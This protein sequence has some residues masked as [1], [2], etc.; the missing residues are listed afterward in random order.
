MIGWIRKKLAGLF[1]KKHVEGPR[2]EFV[3]LDEVSVYSLLASRKGAIPTELT[4]TESETVRHSLGGSLGANIPVGSAGLRSQLEGS[5]TRGTQVVRK[6]TVQASFKD[7]VE[8]ETGKM[9]LHDS[10]SV[11]APPP[12]SSLEDLERIRD[13]GESGHLIPVSGLARGDLL[14][15]EVTLDAEAIFQA[16]LMIATMLGFFEEAPEFFSMDPRDLAQARGVNRVFDELLAGLVPIRGQSTRFERILFNGQE[17]IAS[18][19]LLRQLN[20]NVDL[21]RKPLHIVGVTEAE[22][23]W[24]DLR[25]VLFSDSRFFVMFR[26][27]E[28]GLSSSWHPVKVVEL[29]E[30]FIPQVGAMINDVGPGFIAGVAE[31]AATADS[32]QGPEERAVL[33]EYAEA[34]AEE[35][36]TQWSP[37]DADAVGMDT[38]AVDFSTIE[39]QRRTLAPLVKRIEERTSRELDRAR[40]SDMRERLM[41]EHGYRSSTSSDGVLPGAEPG[42]DRPREYLLDSE[43]VAIHW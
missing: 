16:S 10:V 6:S 23:F 4:D 7:L 18:K 15:L 25:R 11:E 42:I 12:T 28:D 3:Y 41:D 43:I 20:P 36:E 2:R 26:L 21:D 22:L 1:G 29:L 17:F 33:D 13:E 32:Q 31:G 38:L 9:Q 14:E 37:D 35:A 27:N 24:R 40:L 8:H 34:V 5:R 19:D 39:N 30:R